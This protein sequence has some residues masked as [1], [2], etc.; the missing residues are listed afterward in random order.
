MPSVTLQKVEQEQTVAFY[1]PEVCKLTTNSW[2]NRKASHGHTHMHTHKY[3]VLLLI[4]LVTSL[5]QCFCSAS[6]LQEQF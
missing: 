4:W 5:P 1:I 2:L 3:R 6:I